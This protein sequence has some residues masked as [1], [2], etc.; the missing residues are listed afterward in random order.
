MYRYSII[1]YALTAFCTRILCACAETPSCEG[2]GN[3]GV[4][5]KRFLLQTIQILGSVS[6]LVQTI[7]P[8]NFD[9]FTHLIFASRITELTENNPV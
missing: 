2:I 5:D 8:R 9:S 6:P 3:G 1:M 4:G 7:L